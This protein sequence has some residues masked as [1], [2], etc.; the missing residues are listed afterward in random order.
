[1]RK[2]YVNFEIKL[3]IV[4]VEPG[5]ERLSVSIYPFVAV[6]EGVPNSHTRWPGKNSIFRM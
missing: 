4:D 6:L 1:M 5:T 2:L 3:F